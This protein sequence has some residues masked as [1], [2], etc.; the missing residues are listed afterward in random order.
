M[1]VKKK[2]N[3]AMEKVLSE[4]RNKSKRWIAE[5]Q[6]PLLHARQKLLP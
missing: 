4:N 2:E 6:T 3:T 5:I 1:K